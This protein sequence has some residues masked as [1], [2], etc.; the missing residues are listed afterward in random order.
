MLA[1]WP[2][3]RERYRT[4]TTTRQAEFIELTLDVRSS[5]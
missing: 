5:T 4:G 1:R 2:R 3:L